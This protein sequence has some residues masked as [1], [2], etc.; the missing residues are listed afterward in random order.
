MAPAA[1]V[2][3]AADTSRS[4]CTTTGGKQMANGNHKVALP[5]QVAWQTTAAAAASAALEQAPASPGVGMFTEDMLRAAAALPEGSAAAWWRQ[6]WQLHGAEMWNPMIPHQ[7]PAGSCPWMPP[8][9]LPVA[10]MGWG[11]PDVQQQRLHQQLLLQPNSFGRHAAAALAAAAPVHLPG[12]LLHASTAGGSGACIRSQPDESY[13]QQACT[14]QQPIQGVWQQE[15]QLLWSALQAQQQ[16]QQWQQHMGAVH[17]ATAST[18]G[19]HSSCR[20]L[21]DAG[22]LVQP[23]SAP[24]GSQR[25]HGTP[26]LP[27]L[28]YQQTVM[29]GRAS[30]GGDEG[31]NNSC[32]GNASAQGS[33]NKRLPGQSSRVV[34][35]STLPNVWPVRGV[36]RTAA[37]GSQGTSAVGGAIKVYKADLLP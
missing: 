3:K 19:T 34:G 33:D 31:H 5:K 13:S 36:E 2:G 15:Q 4:S 6:Q 11:T 23:H 27:T 1:W 29:H 22:V 14:L 8:P 26:L 10:M 30:A 25:S 16:Q 28:R 9:L 7:A 17:P 32:P 12:R 35:G 18:G 20:L 21:S 24:C 37:A